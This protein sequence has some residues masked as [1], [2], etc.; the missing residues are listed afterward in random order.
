[1]YC[2]KWGHLDDRQN[3]LKNKTRGCRTSEFLQSIRLENVHGSAP[4]S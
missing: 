2:L 1:M 3:R 4:K